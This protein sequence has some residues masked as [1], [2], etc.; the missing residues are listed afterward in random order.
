MHVRFVLATLFVGSTVAAAQ[1]TA[2][3]PP[4]DP[5]PPEAPA[6]APEPPEQAP[7]PTEPAPIVTSPPSV[8]PPITIN[9]TNNNTGNNSNTNTQ[10]NTAPV[11]VSTPVDVSTTTSTPVTVST[12]VTTT[13][14][15]APIVPPG[16]VDV[17]RGRHPTIERVTIIAPKP[18]MPRWLTIGVTGGEDGPGIRASIDILRRGRFSLGIAANAHGRGF[19]HH[20]DD[21]GGFDEEHGKHGDVDGTASAVVY[22]AYTKQIGRLQLRAQIGFGADCDNDRD[23]DDDDDDRD[24][25]TIARSVGG[26]DDDDRERRGSPRAEA[27]L[28]VALPLTKRL[29]LVAGPIVSA[30]RRDG[31]D[32]RFDL[33]DDHRHERPDVDARFMAGLRFG[34]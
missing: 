16:L 15:V 7:T 10:T 32:R 25:N 11:T 21:D 4:E 28:L 13:T 31:D 29:G 18:R 27:A 3:P 12:P 30:T 19:G 1:P 14:T 22:L 9:I 2:P 26:D 34:F 17:N 24:D 6:D 5:Y 23:D 8:V 33:D 20:G